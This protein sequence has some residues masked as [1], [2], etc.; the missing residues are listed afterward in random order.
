MICEDTGLMPGLDTVR[1]ALARIERQ[2]IVEQR[3][4][5]AGGILPD[6]NVCSKGTRLVVVP[7]CRRARRALH[8]AREQVSNRVQ[9]RELLT[10]AQARASVFRPMALPDDRQR[11]KARELER[12][13]ARQIEALRELAATWEAEASE[14]PPE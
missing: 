12:E 4:L 7:Q 10:L 11:E 2:G 8:A 9:R 13:K 3:W 5:V 14:P 1:R 6:G